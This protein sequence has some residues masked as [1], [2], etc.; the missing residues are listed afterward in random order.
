MPAGCS[1]A[2]SWTADAAEKSETPLE[3][4]ASSGVS[5]PAGRPPAILRPVVAPHQALFNKWEYARR[6]E[7]FSF[8][9]QFFAGILTDLRTNCVVHAEKEPSI[10]RVDRFIQC[11]ASEKFFLTNPP[12]RAYTVAKQIKKPMTKR[13]SD[14]PDLLREP[15]V[16]GLRQGTTA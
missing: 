4:S 11:L 14:D 3:A 1:R 12:P 10:G 6:R 5:H 16:V 15:Q 9:K 7:I 13:S 8:F 2:R